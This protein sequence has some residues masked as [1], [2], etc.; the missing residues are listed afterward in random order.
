M[1]QQQQ[2]D[3]KKSTY[4]RGDIERHKQ[5][6]QQGTANRGRRGVMCRWASLLLCFIAATSTSVRASGVFELELIKLASTAQQD[7]VVATIQNEQQQEE[8]DR[9]KRV[10]VCLK[11]AFTSHP[12]DYGPCT[13]GNATLFVSSSSSSTSPTNKNQ[14]AAT[15]GEERRSQLQLTNIVRIPIT[16]KWTVSFFKLLVFAS[17]RV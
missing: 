4:R 15:R 9:L 5:Q 17:Q 14:T 12:V 11:E 13:F 1:D 6:Y 10:F 7:V 16:F 8:Q 2:Q 3:A